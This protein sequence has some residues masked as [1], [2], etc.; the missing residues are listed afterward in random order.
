MYKQMRWLVEN[1]IPSCFER[2]ITGN[3]LLLNMD[4][5]RTT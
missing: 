4:Y 1:E 5:V 3:I 2:K